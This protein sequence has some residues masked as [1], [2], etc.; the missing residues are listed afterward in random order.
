MAQETSLV[1]RWEFE[2]GSWFTSETTNIRADAQRGDLGTAIRAEETLALDDSETVL[3]LSAARRLG[4]R[5]QLRL[6][7]LDYSRDGR[8]EI[9][10]EIRIR[11]VVFPATAVV[12]T[13]W[14]LTF[15]DLTYTY[16]FSLR[17]KTAWGVTGGV[18]RWD[19][20]V[21]VAASGGPLLSRL[22]TDV[23]VDEL[24]PQ[25]G[26]A[27][28]HRPLPKTQLRA[29]IS[30]VSVDLGDEKASVLTASAQVDYRAFRRFG[31]ALAFDYSDIDFTDA[32]GRFIGD[33]EYRVTG[34]QV[35]IPIYLD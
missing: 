23:E 26:L 13:T 6:R 27:W 34:V 31:I 19:F 15:T 30:G 18:G 14:D 4:R 33:Y 32:G 22:G 1:P 16:F 8:R 25:V 12:D 35:F 29:G 24:V 11:D 17:D 21:E 2:V 5:H 20:N 3:R 28:R 7:Y 10:F 9:P